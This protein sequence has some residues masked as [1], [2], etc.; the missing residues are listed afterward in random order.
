MKSPNRL[1]RILLPACLLSGFALA[2]VAGDEDP[3][4]VR[5]GER[6]FLETR[7]AQAYATDPAT[8]DPVLA[9]SVTVDS[10]LP[11]PFAGKH[12]NCRACHLIDEHFRSAGGGM[13]SYTDF[14]RHSPVPLRNDG[15]TT[16]P[17]NSQSLV[18]ISTSPVLHHDGE[19]AT[20]EDL[21]KA[22][23]TGR[24]YGWQPSEQSQAVRHIARVL[25]EDDGRGELAR[26]F[27][28]RYADVLAGTGD[29]VPGKFRLPDAYRLAID[30]ASDTQIL[31]HVARLV[32]AYMRNLEFS[33]DDNGQYNGSPY[34]AFLAKNNLPRKPDDN[35]TVRDYNQRLADAVARLE[36][37]QFVPPTEAKFRSHSQDFVFGATELAG[38]KIFFRRSAQ[39]GTSAGNCIACHAAPDFTD[40]NFH[41]TGSSQLG[42]DAVHG[43]GAFAR[44]AI[45]GLITRRDSHAAYLPATAHHPG[46]SGRF[47]AAPDRA[48]PD[49]AD[50]GLWN[51]FAN[52][53]LP[54]PQEKLR[55]LLCEPGKAHDCSDAA[56]LP[57][58]IARFR[59]PT[60][61]DLGHSAPYLH[62][63]SATTLGNIVTF[64]IRV[65]GL[66]RSNRLRNS[67]P[68]LAAIHLDGTDITPLTAFLRA[69]NEDYE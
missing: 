63:G 52:P 13:R 35:E 59:T 17:R 44:L 10:K 20:M 9:N 15:H 64:Y 55:R 8:P 61:R 41:N 56:L 18:N 22:T 27:G 26:E 30:T 16:T 47:R 68:E 42:Y 40:M 2:A 50:L 62:D 39:A 48:Y 38:M 4:E 11:G 37:P 3:P 69:L 66:A 31:D 7:F 43:D 23:L 58:T 29:A 67:D 25:R 1:V 60:L 49:R 53:D 34:D 32:A 36:Q 24:N 12:M 21:V 33:R 19:F 57:I 65:S 6:L 28:G 45:P 14:A 46:A 51:V 5:V 54:G